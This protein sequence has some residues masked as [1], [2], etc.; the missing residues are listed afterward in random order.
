MG[1]AGHSRTL[2]RCPSVMS[3]SS[4]IPSATSRCVSVARGLRLTISLVAPVD[5]RLRKSS[6]AGSRWGG[7]LLNSFL[8]SALVVT[9]D[10]G[11]FFW[12][13]VMRWSPT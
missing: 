9:A 2:G 3:L 10:N 8:L 5:R 11:F 6:P 7:L 1:I 12:I 13:Q 4:S